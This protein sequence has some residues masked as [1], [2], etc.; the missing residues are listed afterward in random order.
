MLEKNLP[1]EAP[2]L[3]VELAPLPPEPGFTPLYQQ[4]FYRPLGVSAE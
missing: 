1:L 2:S 4:T 3:P